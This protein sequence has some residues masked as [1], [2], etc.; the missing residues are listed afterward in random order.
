MLIFDQLKKSDRPLRI[1]SGII[2]LCMVLL[3]A[4]L[5]YIQIATS[6][7]YVKSLQIQSYR[8]VPVASIRGK[9]L[10]KNGTPLA[11]SRPS[12][13]IVL[14][15]ED[16]RESFH[17]QYRR[18]RS[19]KRRN[20]DAFNGESLGPL[21]RYLAVSNIVS[22][23][24]GIIQRPLTLD[25][26][27]FHRHYTQKPALPVTLAEDLSFKEL[28]LFKEYPQK[29]AGVSL[30]IQPMRVYPFNAFA[31]HSIGYVRVQ[32]N[33]EPSDLTDFNYAL[34]ELR[35]VS[36]IE[37]AFNDVLH[38]RPGAKSIL[39]N[40][41]GYR[42]SESTWMESIPGK[43]IYLTID[44]R[45]QK[46]AEEALASVAGNIKGAVVVMDPRNGDL[47]AVVSMPEFDPGIFT[48]TLSSKEWE[49]LND[50]D[51]RPA[52]NRATAGAYAPGSI[53][54]II[55]SLAGLDSGAI[56][57]DENFENPGFIRVGRRTISDT[58]PPGIYDFRRAF[59]LSSNT[60]FIHFG[61]ETGLDKLIEISSQLLLG[62]RTGIPVMQESSGNLPT[63]K[64]KNNTYGLPW[65]NGDT[66]NL[67]IGQGP[68]TV[69]PLQM[70][71]MTSAI[72]NGGKV[73]APRIV[74]RVSK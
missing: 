71:V 2:L 67:C 13:N 35:G 26:E 6:K 3:A 49:E 39:V 38:G 41:L 31:A 28:A 37:G 14:T 65:T 17:E 68:I 53:Y 69:T 1:L 50:P 43:N 51:R 47:L 29:P 32:K 23:L 12:Y 58:A 9:I 73:F 54:K 62:R 10:D 40:N 36:G 11:D 5:W 25:R 42:Q 48:P 45:I 30:Q 56:D 22:E 70:A 7:K 24:S 74:Q 57:P 33:P 27:E 15:L 55:V 61:L 18:L 59:K 46:T 21:A 4:L 52:F 64:W 72:A 34:T 66:A 8:T 44:A 16:I 60:Y 63:P 20:A 19:L